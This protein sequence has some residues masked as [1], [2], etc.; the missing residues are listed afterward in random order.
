MRDK[1]VK[2]I[3]TPARIKK[4]LRIGLFIATSEIKRAN[5]WTTLL[6]IVVM[7]LTFLNLV[8]V[9][10]VLVGL[11]EGA[12]QANQSRY[13]SDVIITSLP[14]R[15][16]IERSNE[17]IN[18]AK[19]LP[20]A[21]IT[22]RYVSGVK[23]EA[24]YKDRTRLIEQIDTAGGTISGINPVAENSV[25]DLGKY[26][27]DGKYLDEDDYDQII[28]GANLLYKYTPID[29][30]EFKNLKDVEVGSKVRVLINGYSREMTVKGVVKTKADSVDMRSFITD[31]QMRQLLGRSDQNVNEISIKVSDGIKPEFI[32]D[33]IKSMGYVDGARIQTA[34]EAEPKF[35]K[36]IKDTFNLLG[37]IIGTIGLAVACITIFIIIFVNAITRRRYIGIMKGIGIESKSIEFSYIL[38][39][40]FYAV[41]GIII[42]SV[43]V[44]MVLQPY[45]AVNP[46]NF[47]F[48]DGILVATPDGTFWRAV[49]LFFATMIAGYIPARIVVKQNTLDAI[50]GR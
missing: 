49:I 25:T 37:N 15:Q 17:I 1:I 28:L 6:I 31:K 27:V 18:F 23:I 24:N 4:M 26:I 34:L 11:I 46:I 47:P 30:P 40:V 33:S 39:S 35:I 29:S 12:V 42:G 2:L 44:F 19:G 3:N 36:D 9:S 21:G 41:S 5:I 8:V 13:T 45:F 7:M 48:S 43:I 22:A 32:R 10:G 50:L 20:I 14:N 16:Y 38:Q